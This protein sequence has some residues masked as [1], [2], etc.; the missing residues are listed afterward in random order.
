MTH[1]M[2]PDPLPEDP[3]TLMDNW[4]QE[5]RAAAVE[6]NPDAMVLA[7]A[8]HRGMPSARVVLCKHLDREMGYIV[9]Y[10][11]YLSIKAREMDERPRVSCCFYWDS[12]G[13]QARLTGTAVRSS[14]HENDSY[15]ATRDT[16]SQLGAWASHQ[17]QILQSRAELLK[18]LEDTR[19]RFDIPPGSE[20]SASGK[21][22]PR[23]P[24]WGGYRVWI[25]SV[26]LW[27][28]EPGR[29]HDRAIWSRQLPDDLKDVQAAS[30][31]ESTRLQ[32]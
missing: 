7:S 12:A 28:A 18:Q 25:D 27:T 13:R 15:F 4:L 14:N 20:K 1:D 17:S 31:W 2:L 9:F 23:P 5:A 22:I 29:L 8:D 26:E 16:L 30:R 10:T 6:R 19:Q 21:S 11:N 32:P 3:M 24:H